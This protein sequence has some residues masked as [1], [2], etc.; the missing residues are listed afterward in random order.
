MGPVHKMLPGVLHPSV[1][2]SL[3]GPAVRA[4]R[5]T[6]PT[7]LWK[8]RRAFLNFGSGNCQRISEVLV[9]GKPI[10]NSYTMCFTLC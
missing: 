5:K 2:G 1:G 10:K 7:V 3:E 8:K 4:P 6:I 9:M